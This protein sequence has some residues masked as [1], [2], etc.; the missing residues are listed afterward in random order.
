[1]LGPGLPF[2]P[3]REVSAFGGLG[4]QLLRT[5]AWFD[6]NT[7]R[8]NEMCSRRNTAAANSAVVS[9]QQITRATQGV[10]W[11]RYNTGVRKCRR[12]DQLADPTRV[13]TEI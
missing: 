11:E 13:L 2:A 8:C 12:F 3:G 1:M 4:G 7:F 6:A 9:P 10:W 5:R